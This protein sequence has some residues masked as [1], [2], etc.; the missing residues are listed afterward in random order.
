MILGYEEITL[1]GEDVKRAGIHSTYVH[2]V[3]STQ[4]FMQV[5]GAGWTELLYSACWMWVDPNSEIS[6]PVLPLLY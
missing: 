3:L 5:L 6:V 1:I 2:R 4:A